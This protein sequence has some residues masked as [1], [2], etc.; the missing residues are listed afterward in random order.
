MTHILLQARMMCNIACTLRHGR[1]MFEDIG[2]KGPGAVAATPFS[3]LFHLRD[4]IE[5][6]ARAF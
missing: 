5:W 4:F 3:W 6:L 1:P 2:A